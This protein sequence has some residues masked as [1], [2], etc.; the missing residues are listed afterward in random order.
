MSIK[1]KSKQVLVV[2]EISNSKE[3]L[4]SLHWNSMEYDLEAVHKGA[5]WN[6]ITLP[7]PVQSHTVLF[8]SCSFIEAITKTQTTVIV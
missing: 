5:C 3:K 4:S 8:L 1:V 2:K 6:A 7:I